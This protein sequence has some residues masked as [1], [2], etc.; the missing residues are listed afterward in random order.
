MNRAAALAAAVLLCGAVPAGALQAPANPPAIPQHA[1][2][3]ERFHLLRA[4][5]LLARGAHERASASVAPLRI[6]PAPGVHLNT[7]AAPAGREAAEA[8]L[9]DAMQAWNQAGG[10][11]FRQE[12][13]PE[14]AAL[15]IV[16]IPEIAAAE[17]GR[18]VRKCLDG[19]LILAMPGDLPVRGPRRASVRLAWMTPQRTGPHSAQSLRH[20]MGQALGLY[21]GLAPTDEPGGIMGPDTHDASV[22]GT[23]SPAEVERATGLMAARNALSD[24]AAKRAAVSAKI[25]RIAPVQ[26][27][28][29]AGELWRGDKAAYNFTIRNTG[30]APLEIDVKPNC[31]CTVAR[32][33]QVIPPGGEGRIEAAM[34]THSFRGK[35]SKSINV[36]STDPDSPLTLLRIAAQ[37]KPIVDVTPPS[38]ASIALASAGPTVKEFQITTAGPDPVEVKGVATS[39]RHAQARLEPAPPQNGR[40]AYKLVLTVAPDAP[41]GRSMVVVTMQNTSPREPST[42]LT[43]LCDKGIVAIPQNVFLGTVDTRRQTPAIQILTLKKAG[44]SFRILEAAAEDPWLEVKPQTV[45]EGEYRVT[46]TCRGPV[47]PGQIRTKVIVKTDDPVQPRIEVPVM[48]QVVG[49]AESGR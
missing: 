45:A 25:P 40:P 12:A 5:G 18:L 21:L 36:Y 23:P 16:L 10:F 32:F 34:D 47:L 49:A 42:T 15:T 14:Q 17:D 37:V 31:G 48:G 43:V 9:R 7:A 8:A 13:A 46:L 26:R 44:G 20:L 33:D 4:A 28:L 6:P 30:E 11:G 3:V 41:M 19:G 38:P 39:S 2:R 1:S 22:A 27:E 35:T 29:D 24:L